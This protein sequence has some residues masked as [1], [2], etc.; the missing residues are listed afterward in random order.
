LPELILAP[1]LSL[2]L[3]TIAGFLLSSEVHEEEDD[4]KNAVTALLE[5]LTVK[6]APQKPD[7]VA[8]PPAVAKTIGVF[9]IDHLKAPEVASSK[10][11]A[12]ANKNK[13]G[14]KKAAKDAKKAAFKKGSAAEKARAHTHTHTHWQR[15]PR[16][17][18]E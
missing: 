8:V 17:E 3:Q 4:A 16:G 12:A 15:L 5:A 10:G 18:A 13:K 1:P 11:I 9:D 2:R 6:D 14:D 7:P